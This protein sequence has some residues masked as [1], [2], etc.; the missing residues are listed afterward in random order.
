MV[1]HC[2]PDDV[3]QNKCERVCDAAQVGFIVK[4]KIDRK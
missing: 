4:T 1:N 2:K 3:Q